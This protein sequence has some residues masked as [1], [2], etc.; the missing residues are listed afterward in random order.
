MARV[1]GKVAIVTGGASGL[2]RASALALAREG[3]RLVVTDID[4][5]GG[6]ATVQA[7][8]AA[9]G[10]AVFVSHDVGDESDWERAIQAA[11]QG[12]GRLD[13]LVNNAGIGVSSSLLDMSL[14]EW[15]RV[16]RVNLDGVFLGTKLGVAAMRAAEPGP[17]ENGGGS[18]VNISSILGL[19]GA[20]DTTAYSAS[21]GGVRLLTKAAALECAAKGWKVRVNSIH[22]GYIWTPMVQQGVRRRA[23]RQ[24]TAEDG[25]RDYL[26][27]Q[28]PIGRLGRPEDIAHGVVY[29]ASDE[30]AFMTGAELVIDGGY[31][32]R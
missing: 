1:A 3:A 8:R 4:I 12:L 20:P 22:P 2:G 28:H 11:V 13:V 15:R 26:L 7:V 14:A 29:L 10:E 6:D 21:K 16:M 9:G 30:S 23:Q 5:D 19:V 24:N 18:I 27:A 25:I 17:N 31:T 32:A